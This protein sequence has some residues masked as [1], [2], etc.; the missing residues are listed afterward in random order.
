[1]FKD[2]YTI[3]EIAKLANKSVGTIYNLSW[4]GELPPPRQTFG[5]FNLYAKEDIRVWI[6]HQREKRTSTN[7]EGRPRKRGRP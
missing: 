5:K 4:A 2:L 7:T 6:K 1:M 3:S